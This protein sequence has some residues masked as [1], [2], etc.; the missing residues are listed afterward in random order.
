MKNEKN[1]NKKPDLTAE[2][3]TKVAEVIH[4]TLPDS[5]TAAVILAAG[6]STRMGA[7]NKQLYEINEKPV[8][9]HTLI[10][11][12][13]CPLIREIV[14]VTKPADFEAIYRMAKQYKITK[15]KQVVGGGETRQESAR[16]GVE[17]LDAKVKFVAIADG[18]RC[19]T[20]PKQISRVCLMAY[21]TK[22]ACAGHLISDTVKRASVIG[23]VRETVDR[24]GLWQVQTPQVFHTALYQAALFKAK[25]DDFKC[26]D[27]AS[28]LEH[29]GYQVRLVECGP[30]NI[31]LTTPA[32]IPLASALLL[33]RA[34]QE[35]D[36]K[37]K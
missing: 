17:K 23:N 37:K 22:A 34:T 13:N 7:F 18:A 25:K 29:L 11:Y 5:Y 32:D 26:T 28:L 15:L 24:T 33:M 3:I 12:Q 1:A 31:K 6:A 27:D 9:A 2:Q 4:S 35:K 16:I 8:L 10:A 19:L 20:T 21:R 30:T 36:Q 14:V